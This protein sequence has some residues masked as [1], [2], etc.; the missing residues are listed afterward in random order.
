MNPTQ[1]LLISRLKKKIFRKQIDGLP[2]QLLTRYY[3]VVTQWNLFI[4]Y[5]TFIS[6]LDYVCVADLERF[7]LTLRMND[8]KD[9]VRVTNR[10]HLK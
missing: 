6:I 2:R 1:F 5:H 3:F 7:E 10:T 4:L 9:H 8:G